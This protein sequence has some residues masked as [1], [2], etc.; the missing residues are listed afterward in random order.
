MTELNN[1]NIKAIADLKPGYTLGAA[2]VALLQEMA[3]RLLSSEAQ[4]P[5]AWRY[6]TTD[7][8]GNPNP[9][10][11]FSEEA[12]LLGLYQPLYA[13]PQPVAVP[14]DIPRGLA[15]QIVSLLA[16]NIG[17]KFLAQKIWN[18]CRAAMLNAEPVSQPYTLPD[19]KPSFGAMMRALDAFYADEDV[20]ENAMLA[21]FKILIADMRDQV[22][23]PGAVPD[24]VRDAINRLLDNDGSRGFF[25]LIRSNEAREELE[26]LL[27]AAHQEVKGE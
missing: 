23:K 24:K 25:S 13:A 27:A 12:S 3:R 20:P 17:D 19:G 2:D 15:G 6:R 11:S 26:Q 16:H 8:N 5:V 22:A 18:A 7:I 14:E 21:A 4:E 1:S 9:H 10:W